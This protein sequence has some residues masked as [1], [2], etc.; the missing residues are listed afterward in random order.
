MLAGRINVDWTSVKE[1]TVR[2][3]AEGDKDLKPFCCKECGSD[4]IDYCIHESFDGAHE[5]YKY[6]CNGCKHKWVVEG[7]DY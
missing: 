6:R 4:D 5:D 7:P 1:E 2:L 3:R